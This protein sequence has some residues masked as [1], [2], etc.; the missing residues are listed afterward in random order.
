[1]AAAL[2]AACAGFASDNLKYGQ[3]DDDVRVVDREGYALGCKAEWKT[4]RWVMYRLTVDEVLTPCGR[5]RL[6]SP[7]LASLT[8]VY[9]KQSSPNVADWANGST[10][11]GLSA[12]VDG[13]ANADSVEVGSDVVALDSVGVV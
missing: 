5:D 10:V 6:W 3:P 4:A 11:A 1:M 9:P 7:D 12:Y 8:N 2:I 13:V